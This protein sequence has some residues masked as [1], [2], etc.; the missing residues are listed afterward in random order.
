MKFY[1]VNDLAIGLS[2]IIQNVLPHPLLGAPA[3]NVGPLGSLNGC[4]TAVGSLLLANFW[5]FLLGGGKIEVFWG[6]AFPPKLLPLLA[7]PFQERIL[8]VFGAIRMAPNPPR[9]R[10]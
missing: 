4:F 7:V 3:R 2:K 9:I 10:S 6:N 5:F 1:C 8:R